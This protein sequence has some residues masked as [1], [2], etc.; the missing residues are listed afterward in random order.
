MTVPFPRIEVLIMQKNLSVL[1]FPV[2]GSIYKTAIM[3]HVTEVPIA[4]AVHILFNRFSLPNCG[5][6]LIFLI[7]PFSLFI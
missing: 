2:G 3:T 5:L 6:I 4:L 1:Y 7:R